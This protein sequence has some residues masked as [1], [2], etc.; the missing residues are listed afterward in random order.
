M[1]TRYFI[2]ILFLTSCQS[3]KSQGIKDLTLEQIR[4]DILSS[5][6]DEFEIDPTELSNQPIQIFQLEVYSL[7]HVEY[8]TGGAEAFMK[9]SYL[10]VYERENNKWRKKNVLPYNY[11]IKLI[12]KRLGIFLTEN[13]FC[14]MAFKCT[15][16]VEFSKFSLNEMA[17]IFSVSG[18]D[19]YPYCDAL[20][21]RNREEELKK[22]IG[23]TITNQIKVSSYTVGQNGLERIDLTG[24][25]RLLA[26][27][28]KDLGLETIDHETIKTVYL[29]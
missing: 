1:K 22:F 11:D 23:D 16:Y 8:K 12:D 19:N 5:S 2:Y 24:T 29:K 7:A 4:A 10:L 20:L 18:Y 14:D 3:L 21:S 26:S 6:Q 15:G 28:D 13:F 17:P 27:W 9:Q 25:I